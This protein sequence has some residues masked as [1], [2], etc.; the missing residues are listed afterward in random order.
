MSFSP[1]EF[2][3]ARYAR[4]IARCREAGV[5]MHDDAGVAVHVQRVLLASDFAFDVLQ[6]DPELLG[7]AGLAFM[8]NPHH[9]DARRL[10]LD[11]SMD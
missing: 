10:V 4:L 1:S 11:S 5:A 8:A 9:A 7:A 2:T 3:T 6:R